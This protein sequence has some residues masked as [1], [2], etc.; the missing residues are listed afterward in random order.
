MEK[1]QQPEQNKKNSIIGHISRWLIYIDDIILLIVA[2]GIISVA[3]LLL[4][5]TTPHFIYFTQYSFSHIIGDLMFVLIIMELFRQ[6]LRQLTHQVFSLSPFF[7]IGI[8]ASIRGILLVQMKLAMGE[9]EWWGGVIQLGVD[10]IIVLI[11][12]VSYYFYSKV[13]EKGKPLK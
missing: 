1:H 5:E 10:A 12:I 3:V 6:V 11:L 13:E 8:I 7:F 2:V 9:T 4:I